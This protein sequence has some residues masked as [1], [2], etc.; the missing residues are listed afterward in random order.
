VIR[1]FALRV[2]RMRRRM[3]TRDCWRAL[4]ELVS[5]R[6]RGALLLRRRLQYVGG[7]S[8]SCEFCISL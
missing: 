2:D 8:S 3:H 7:D 4:A 6:A 1:C 5:L